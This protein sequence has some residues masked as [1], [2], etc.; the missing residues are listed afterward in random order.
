M[1]YLRTLL[2]PFLEL[3][4]Q[5]RSIKEWKKKFALMV[6]HCIG[7]LFQISAYC[8]Q[9]VCVNVNILLK[10]ISYENKAEIIEANGASHTEPQV[11]FC[12]HIVTCCRVYM[13]KCKPESYF[14]NDIVADGA[15][16]FSLSSGFKTRINKCTIRGLIRWVSREEA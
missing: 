14:N 12:S 3:M 15:S 7:I 1:T 10:W 5:S 11:L 13:R 9:P 8:H 16:E 2:N 4:P 6:D